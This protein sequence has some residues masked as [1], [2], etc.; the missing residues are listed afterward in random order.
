[1]VTICNQVQSIVYAREA[2]YGLFAHKK[3]AKKEVIQM[4]IA[5]LLIIV[6]TAIEDAFQ[7]PIKL[8]FALFVWN[9]V[10]TITKADFQNKGWPIVSK[11]ITGIFAG[12]ESKGV[13]I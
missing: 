7:W 10:I 4:D 2:E 11:I 12:I 1:M 6:Q 9:P 8:K 3:R 13:K 5:A